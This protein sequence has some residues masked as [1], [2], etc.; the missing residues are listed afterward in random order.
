MRQENLNPILG[1]KNSAQFIYL[2]LARQWLKHRG[3]LEDG[4]LLSKPMCSLSVPLV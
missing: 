3:R 2:M 1:M 4:K